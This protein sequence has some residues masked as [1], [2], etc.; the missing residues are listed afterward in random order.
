MRYLIDAGIISF[1]KSHRESGKKVR[2]LRI[3]VLSINQLKCLD[4]PGDLFIKTTSQFAAE[5]QNQITRQ[6][7]IR[8]KI[9]DIFDTI[10]PDIIAESETDFIFLI[11]GGSGK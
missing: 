1:F 2:M 7:G 10:Q 3:E 11:E 9:H 8:L 4:K 5:C 6:I